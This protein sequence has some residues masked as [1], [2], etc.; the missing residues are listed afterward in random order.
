MIKRGYKIMVL[1]YNGNIKAKGGIF[2]FLNHYS[3]TDSYYGANAGAAVL[4]IYL[5]IWGIV[6]LVGIVKYIFQGIGLYSIAR[7]QGEEAPW[8]AFVPF[9]RTYLHGKLA[10][11]L[12]IGNKRVKK[13]GLWLLVLPICVGLIIGYVYFLFIALIMVGGIEMYKTGGALFSMTLGM[14]LF[15]VFLLGVFVVYSAVINTLY[16]FV[17]YQIYSRYVPHKRALLHVFLSLFVPMYQAIYL[18]VLRNHLD[19]KNHP[20]NQSLPGVQEDKGTEPGSEWL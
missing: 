2:M 9:A 13:P 1:Y 18:F 4:G 20:A 8:L 15:F 11:E 12:E 16:G 19:D 5:L 3:V 6:L 17:N 14:L 7:K 10:G